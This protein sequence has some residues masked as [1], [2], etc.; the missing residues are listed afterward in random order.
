M[1]FFFTT[2][3]MGGY[4]AV[5]DSEEEP[6]CADGFLPQFLCRRRPADV[7]TSFV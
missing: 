3:F 4:N 6:A 5:H 2:L 7:T 1:S